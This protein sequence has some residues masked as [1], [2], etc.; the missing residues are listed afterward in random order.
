[1]CF[2]NLL[3]FSLFLRFRKHR[4]EKGEK[5]GFYRHMSPCYQKCAE[6]SIDALYTLKSFQPYSYKSWVQAYL[7]CIDIKQLA[8]SWD[9]AGNPRCAREATIH[10]LSYI[11]WGEMFE[12]SGETRKTLGKHIKRAINMFKFL[13]IFIRTS[14]T[15]KHARAFTLTRAHTHI[16][17][18]RY[19]YILKDL[20]SYL[21]WH[22]PTTV[23]HPVKN[24]LTKRASG[25]WN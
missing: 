15:H 24:I 17:G 1:M 12:I 7:R 4:N 19:I 11:I 16:C 6:M 21:T 13:D 2:K 3:F 14:H 23:G 20:F 25:V 18:S 9:K 8:W 5:K 22:K 10:P